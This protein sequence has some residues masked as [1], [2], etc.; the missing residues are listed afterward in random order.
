MY[1]LWV[2]QRIKRIKHISLS[3]VIFNFLI[4]MFVCVL[5]AVIHTVLSQAYNFPFGMTHVYKFFDLDLI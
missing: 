4:R 5:I 3:W 2:D 1:Y